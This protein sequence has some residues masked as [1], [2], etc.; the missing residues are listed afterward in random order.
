MLCSCLLY[1]NY[2]PVYLNLPAQLLSYVMNIC[3]YF[4]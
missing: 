4:R 1:L 3:M 2:P